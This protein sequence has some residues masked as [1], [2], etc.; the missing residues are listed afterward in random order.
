MIIL[1]ESKGLLTDPGLA[2]F[3]PVDTVTNVSKI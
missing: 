1:K 3:C 2:I